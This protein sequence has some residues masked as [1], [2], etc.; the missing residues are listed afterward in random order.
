[1]R[2][3]CTEERVA[4]KIVEPC[5]RRRRQSKRKTKFENRMYTRK[6][7]SSRCS[8]LGITSHNSQP[9]NAYLP[10]KNSIAIHILVFGRS[11]SSPCNACAPYTNEKIVYTSRSIIKRKRP[12]KLLST[13]KEE[14]ETRNRKQTHE[15]CNIFPRPSL[16]LFLF[17][18]GKIFPSLR[19]PAE[20]QNTTAAYEK[21]YVMYILC[22]MCA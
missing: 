14:E 9:P 16:S 4:N 11:C 18:V 8:M 10:S 5:R 20:R 6:R 21:A 12:S 2:R 17:F 15:I 22:V 13:K 7:I 1:M 3:W 19:R